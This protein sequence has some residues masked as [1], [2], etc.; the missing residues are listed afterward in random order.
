MKYFIIASALFILQGTLQA[1]EPGQLSLD[2]VSNFKAGDAGFSI[3]HRFYG[4]AKDTDTFY[5]LDEGANTYLSLRYAIFESLIIKTHHTSNKSE[6]SIGLAYVH[7]F[8]YLNTQFNANYFSF[9]ESGLSNEDRSNAFVNIVLQSPLLYK[10]LIITSNLGYD[11]YYSASGAGLGLEFSTQNFF[12]KALTFTQSLSFLAEYY[13][14]YDDV[15]DFKR[16]HNAYAFGVKFSTYAHHFELLL[17]NS[18]GVDARTMYQGTNTNDL[19]F[20]FNINRKF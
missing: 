6:N 5:G 15:Q 16:D 4:K 3:R 12:P 9:K 20:A 17:T 18:T 13:T 11:N 2:S 14:K 7:K 1:F 19:H 10:H 8:E